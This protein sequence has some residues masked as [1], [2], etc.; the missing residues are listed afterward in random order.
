[1]HYFI[2]VIIP[3]KYEGGKL[4]EAI[5][6]IL[7]PWDERDGG[8]PDGQWDWWTL[9]GRWNGVWSDD[10]IPVAQLLDNESLRRP[11]AIVAAPDLWCA[12]EK[13]DGEN[14]VKHN[15]YESAIR[16]ELEKRRD[17]WIAV[18]GIHS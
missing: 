6:E 8:N 1:M 2:G 7:A 12:E 3:F 11:Y 13:W 17:C 14:F 18:V 9:G 5:G 10:V 15:D 4:E 16:E